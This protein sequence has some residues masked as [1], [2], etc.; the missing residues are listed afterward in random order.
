MN[1]GTLFEEKE[2]FGS[3]FS[4]HESQVDTKKFEKHWQWPEEL[5]NG[6]LSFIQIRPGF[7]LKIGSYQLKENIDVC[8]ELTSAP[9]TLEFCVAGELRQS[10]EFGADSED[11]WHFK[12]GSRVI[13]LL[14]DCRGISNIPAARTFSSISLEIS[15][16]TLSDLLCREHNETT[17]ELDLLFREGLTT[18]YC[19]VTPIGYPINNLLE[20][21]LASPFE[22]SLRQLHLECKSL[23]LLL[24]SIAPLAHQSVESGSKPLFW[25]D[26]LERIREAKEILLKKMTNPPSLSELASMVGISKSKLTRGF[27]YVYGTSVYDYLRIKRLERAQELL[28]KR[29]TNVTETAFEVGYSQQSNFTKAFKNHFG[30][31]PIDLIR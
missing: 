18:P 14:P 7:S 20:E 3:F 23:E 25:E 9:L 11:I 8:F 24:Y 27:R 16:E 28:K 21:L 22:E 2:L 17:T 10:L 13:T 6:S 30:Y 26:D 15:I 1:K 12:H 19:Q 5:G 31:N 4:S 29:Y